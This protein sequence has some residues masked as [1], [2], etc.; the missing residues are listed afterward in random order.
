MQNLLL[1]TACALS[2]LGGIFAQYVFDDTVGLGRRFDGI[3][4][5]SGGGATSR[6]LVNYPEQQRNEIL[7]YLFKPKFAASLQILKVEIGGDAQSTDGTEAS[8]MHESWDENYQR[9]YEW[10]LMV[11]AKK[12]NPDILLY[13]LPWAFPGWLGGDNLSPYSDPNRTAIYIVKWIQG[14]KRVYNLTIDFV[15]IWNERQYDITYIK[16][17]RQELDTGGL[18]HVRIV[19]ADGGLSIANDIAKDAELAS[20]ID[21]IGV[22]YPGTE[23]STAAIET[24]KQLWASEDYS[25]FNDMTGGGC[26]ARILNQNYVNGLY[27]S[28]ISWNLIASY[29]RGLP[30]YGDGLM[31]AV[32]PWS[33]NYI[34]ESPIW[35]TAHTSQ[36]TN[37]GWSYLSH[38]AG[39][40]KLA[41]GG[42]YVS[43]VSP[44]RKDFSIIIE[45][46]SRN[47]SLC[48]RPE[49]PPYTV[50]PQNITVQLQG[51]M[52][53]I[54]QLNVWY[55]KL[56]FGH[57]AATMFKKLEPIKIVDGKFTLNLAV[58]EIFTLSTVS[59]AQKGTYPT[60]PPNKPFPV[61]YKE[62]FESYQEHSEPNN[63]AQQ[64][65][66]FEVIKTD[67][68]HNNVLRQMVTSF[69][70]AWCQAELANL[71]INLIGNVHWADIDL[72]VEAKLGDE[73]GTS[74]VFVAARVANGGCNADSSPGIY[75]FLSPQ[76]YRVTTDLG[77]TKVILWNSQ[78][79][80]G[81][82][83][84]Q[85]IVQGRTWLHVMSM[86][87]VL[88][89][90]CGPSSRDSV[91]G[92]DGITFC[93]RPVDT[94]C[95]GH[96]LDTLLLT[97]S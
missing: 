62:D 59:T 28:T 80:V 57:L 86:V 39:V 82:N 8:H 50:T 76:T 74:G 40:G 92:T 34:V 14:A 43:L 71:S 9:G 2:A 17:L 88:E 81:W 91:G 64:T 73:N 67:P 29:Y 47:H 58:D 18:E 25:T 52:S 68:P 5:L 24:G 90:L 60:P 7:D 16:T 3:G 15:G 85:L 54:T 61:P 69:P 83:K 72:E 93:D 37:I 41:N 97:V 56:G 96:G 23:S 45:T 19:A 51:S 70:C 36:F 30:Y 38:K 44:D 46:M 11:E 42:S 26:W 65:G 55:S 12:R 48:I 95:D 27:T 78:N 32:S 84:L 49:L 20:A 79:R 35:M 87:R 4:G 1:F 6:L 94:P 66:S 77:R 22:H 13:G 89:P 75:F 10:W 53:G 63:F 33:G 31:T 21:Y